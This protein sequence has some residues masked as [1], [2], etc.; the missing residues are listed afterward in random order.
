MA[1]LQ[2]LRTST[3]S[4]RPIPA[5]MAAGQLALGLHTNSPGAFFKDTNGGLVKIGPVHV[6]T[7]SPNASPAS[8]AAT[9][10]VNGRSYQILTVGNTDFTAIGASANTVGTIFTASGAGTGT[11]TVSG[12]QGNSKGECWLDTS[13]SPPVFKVFNG[14]A[15]VTVHPPHIETNTTT[16]PSNPVVGQLWW[17]KDD[18]RI[19]IYMNDG[20]SAQ[21]VDASPDNQQL[22]WTRTGTR[23]DLSNSGDVV[24]VSGGSASAPGLAV[25]GDLDTGISSSS[26]NTLGISTGGTQR[27][28]VDSSGRVGINSTS[29]E[30]RLHVNGA[31]VSTSTNST[32]SVGGSNR[33][34]LDL[35]SGGARIGH[36]RGS[37]SAGSGYLGLFVD[38]SERMRIE[39]SG[40][41]K[42]NSGFVFIQS[43][44]TGS[45]D[46]DGLALISDTNAD[47]YVWNY[48][49][50]TLRFGTN[51]T[52]RMRIDSAGNVGIGTSSPGE[53]LVVKDTSSANTSTYL[54][55]LS[56]N[57]GNAGVAFGDS[58][59]T[60]VGGILYNNNDN[61]LRFFK[62]GFTEAARIDS[63][64]NVGIGTVSP[65]DFGPSLHVAG[66]DPAFILQDTA[67]AVDYFGINIA[68]GVVANWFDDAAAWTIGTASGVAGTAFSEKMRIDSAGKVGIGTSSPGANLSIGNF[69]GTKGLNL[70]SAT[71]GY[72]YLYFADG[73]SGTEAYRG[74]IQYYHVDDSLQ[75]GSAGI[76]QMR[77]NSAG[78]IGIG[79]NNPHAKVDIEGSSSSEIGMHINN[80][81]GPTSILTSTGGSYSFAGIGPSTS[82]FTTSGNTLAVGPYSSNSILQFVNGGERMRLDS[83]GRL[84]VGTSSNYDANAPVQISSSI[85]WGLAIRRTSNTNGQSNGIIQFYNSSGETVRL[86]GLNDGAQSSGDYPG[87]FVVA[88]TPDGASSPTERMRVNSA[89]RLLVGTDNSSTSAGV[90]LKLNYSSAHPSF[91]IVANTAANNTFFHL[92]NTNATNNGYRFYVQADGGIRN[93]AGNNSSLSDEREKK[94]IV[95]LDDKW[96]KVKAWDIKKFH[97]NDNADTDGKLYGVIAQQVEEHCPEV[98][99]DWV[100]QKAEDAVLDEDGNVVTP[101]VSEILR[102]GVKE[103]QM[104]WMAIKALQEAQARIETLEAKV[105]ALEAG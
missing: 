87:A 52:E 61:A 64:G 4:K 19:Y 68:S 35:T 49:N 72:G 80:T 39:S 32:S 42:F 34:I 57:T 99:T 91:D 54:N 25:A 41:A 29:P 11:G 89:G 3:D 83:S 103:Q 75:F 23:V 104:M 10:T 16:P 28:T 21:W 14:T 47:A 58:D 76:E 73:T 56:G 18:G 66:T 30:E 5:A 26:A 92:Y 85:G 94:N 9:A 98:V 33:A 48:E 24:T 90:G 96:D 1:S 38:S 95:A 20:S 62:S 27:I 101:A 51:A 74:Y 45:S 105:A 12:L 93:F 82:W 77:I 88:T 2:H 43:S 37:T 67:T 79:T 22:F 65:I 55:I 60:L 40:Y 13:V 17:N 53:K 6:G 8:E 50:T 59:A 97:Y 36:F 63:S 81:S 7:T 70:Q 15:F 86:Y 46:S 84:L 78:S 102:K 71:N 31:I 100:K 44:A 69:D